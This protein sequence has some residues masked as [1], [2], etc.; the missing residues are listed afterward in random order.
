MMIERLANKPWPLCP[1]FAAHQA[2]ASRQLLTAGRLS[3]GGWVLC[4]LVLIGW[5]SGACAD[6]RLLNRK[7][8]TAGSTSVANGDQLVLRFKVSPQV[9]SQ[10][11][12]LGDLV[13]VVSWGSRAKEDVLELPLGPAPQG[14]AFQ[15]WTAHDLKRNLE[16]RGIDAT[17]VAW[18]GPETVRLM[19]KREVEATKKA[20]PK[21]SKSLSP[22]FLSDRI[23][24]QAE[25]NLIQATREYLWLESDERTP[26]KI[27]LK[28]P[29]ELANTLAQR[30]NILSLGGGQ[31]P[32]TG[33]QRLVYLIKH[34]GEELELSMT[35]NVELPTTVV[36]AN[37]AIRRGE[38]IDES[39]LA[40]AAL[41]ERMEE[42][43]D[44]FFDDM[45]SMVGK[46]MRRAMS[47]GVPIPRTSIGEPNVISSGEIIEIE[48]VSGSVVVKSAAKAL[49]GGAVGELINIELIPGR[50]RM[51]ATVVGPMLVRITGKTTVRSEPVESETEKAFTEPAANPSA[52]KASGFL[53][54]ARNSNAN[55]DLR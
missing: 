27:S 42:Q 6:D 21:E 11:V 8:G 50:K 37:R 32:W 26:W 35:V 55:G 19:R 22:A 52:D 3:M 45:S 18:H 15:D 49:A 29:A 1:S 28:V 17:K 23:I 39:C 9:D 30:R 34:R 38:V 40:Y 53:K 7:P 4:C 16:F 12:R 33:R 41:P 5:P 10:V 46:Q 43:A 44:Q 51:A 47:T 2:F 13:E 20:A 14:G 31:E 25:E 24:S 36:V 48:S 54:T